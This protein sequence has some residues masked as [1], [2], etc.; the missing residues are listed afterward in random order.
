MRSASKFDVLIFKDSSCPAIFVSAYRFHKIFRLTTFA[1]LPASKTCSS[2]PSIFLVIKLP[3][4]MTECF[5]IIAPFKT[6]ALAA[7]QTFSPICIP[8]V[9]SIQ[10]VVS[11]SV[12]PVKCP[13][14][15]LI[16]TPYPKRQLSPKTIFSSQ[17]IEQFLLQ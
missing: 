14:P 2:F 5:C 12:I 17:E 11:P 1:G 6:A 15:S 7:I 3:Y 16:S 9:L 4:P 8:S 13:S 10:A